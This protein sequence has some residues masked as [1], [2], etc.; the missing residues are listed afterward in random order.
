MLGGRRHVGAQHLR[1]HAD[2]EERVAQVV[3]DDCDEAFP[4]HGLF[5]GALPF[6]LGVVEELRVLHRRGCEPRQLLRK[7]QVMVVVDSCPRRCE[8]DYGEGTA[9]P[10]DRDV[11]CRGDAKP[12]NQGRQLIVHLFAMKAL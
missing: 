10:A 5:F 6:H 9:R 8:D 11:D 1:R 7:D 2:R 3:P 12:L 4:Q